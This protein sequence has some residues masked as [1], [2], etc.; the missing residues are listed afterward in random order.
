MLM[1]G[2]RRRILHRLLRLHLAPAVTAL[3]KLSVRRLFV[4]AS[5][6]RNNPYT[7]FISPPSSSSLVCEFLSKGPKP[8]PVESFQLYLES[9]HLPAAPRC[10]PHRP[11]PP[12]NQPATRLP[13]P[14]AWPSSTTKNNNNN[15][16]R[17][18][19]YLTPRRPDQSS[20]TKSSTAI[21]HLH[22]TAKMRF[23]IL[24]SVLAT[25][26][27][28]QATPIVCSDVSWPLSSPPV[29]PRQQLNRL[30]RPSFG[31]L[32]STGI[33]L[34]RRQFFFFTLQ[35]SWAAWRTEWLASSFFA[36]LV[37][38][39]HPTPLS[40]EPHRKLSDWLGGADSGYSP[41]GMVS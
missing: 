8:L 12:S 39:T 13:A 29:L 34:M 15:S 26:G 2:T 1:L 19:T 30:R 3:D 14:I 37:A 7:W 27:L 24:V 5:F 20:I 36:L 6:P 17:R 31:R 28:V 10:L 16:E 33:S 40:M 4:S 23:Q 25:I 41:S 35:M 18:F 9:R 22:N 38:Q 32:P 11:V 21:I